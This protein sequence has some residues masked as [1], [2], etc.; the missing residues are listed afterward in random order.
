M[1]GAN[2]SAWDHKDAIIYAKQSSGCDI[3]WAWGRASIFNSCKDL[4]HLILW[5]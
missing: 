5:I 2:A 3:L 1:P 4:K